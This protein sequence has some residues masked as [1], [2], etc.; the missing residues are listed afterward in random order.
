MGIKLTKR[1]R[2]T[3]FEN[4]FLKVISYQFAVISGPAFIRKAYHAVWSKSFNSISGYTGW[5]KFNKSFIARLSTMQLITM[6]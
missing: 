4:R 1:F 3:C 5:T 2:N 6:N